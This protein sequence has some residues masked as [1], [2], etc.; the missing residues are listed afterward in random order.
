MATM[1]IESPSLIKKYAVMDATRLTVI[2][3]GDSN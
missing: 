1:I 3:G 2:E